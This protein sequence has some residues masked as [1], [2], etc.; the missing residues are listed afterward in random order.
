MKRATWSW[1][2]VRKDGVRAMF[3]G[4][5]ETA[6][7]SGV[8]YNG[9]F[10]SL[11]FLKKND[12]SEY[13]VVVSKAEHYYKAGNCWIETFYRVWKPTKD[14]GNNL[15]LSLKATEKKS[16]SGNKFFNLGKID[17]RNIEI[18]HKL[19]LMVCGRVHGN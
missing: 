17:T 16:K 4:Y 10:S 12:D 7:M 6:H 8:L 9:T 19:E 5:T 1:E 13:R 14:Q 18:D 11:T 2:D 15:Y 3:P